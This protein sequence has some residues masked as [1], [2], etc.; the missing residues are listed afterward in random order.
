MKHYLLLFFVF[1]LSC[2]E[3]QNHT[4]TNN[5][6]YSY[7]ELSP[8][9]SWFQDNIGFQKLNSEK[10]GITFSNFISEEAIK[11]NRILTNGSGVASGDYNNDGLIDIYFSKLEGPNELYEN[12][13]DLKFK[14]VT[15][16]A[17]VSLSSQ[18]STGVVFEDINGDDFLDLIVGSLDSG[19]KLLINNGDGTF[20]IDS[21]SLKV[22]N[23]IYG[24]SSIAIADI[25]NDGDLD[26]YLTNYKKRSAKD[27]FPFERAFRHIV[28][29]EGDNYFIN[30]KFSEHYKLIERDSVILWYEYG[31][32][33]VLFLNNG[34]GT[35]SN[36]TTTDQSIF[37]TNSE[38]D[39]VLDWG[40]HARFFD[41][42]ND[43][44]PDLYVC[45]DFESP[46]RIW[47][48]QKDGT[49]KEIDEL[50]IRNTS[51][52]S[53]SVAFTDINADNKS[54]IFVA[55][56]LSRDLS[57]RNQQIG[58]M[59]PLPLP[60]GVVDNRPQYL[61]N[62][63]LVSQ[64]NG[65]FVNISDYSTLRASEWSWAS[66]FLDVDLDGNEDLVI[67]TGNYFDTQNADANQQLQLKLSSGRLPARDV[68][69]EYKPLKRPNKIFRNINGEYNFEDVSEEWGFLTEDISHGMS[70]ADLDNDGDLDVITNNLE[71]TAG[72]YENISSNNRIS[73]HLTG[74]KGNNEAVG[75]T[76]R[77]T[78]SYK[79]NTKVQNRNILAGG[80]YGSGS[81]K[82]ASFGI[83]DAE[84]VN[85]E[86]FWYNGSYSIFEDMDINKSYKFTIS[87]ESVSPKP[88]TESIKP[89]FVNE[90]EA[91]SHTHQEK[92]Y[93]DL[94]KKQPLLPYRLS[95]EGPW[96]DSIDFNSDS[97][98]DVLIGNGK[99][100]P[101]KL[102][103]NIE[104]TSFEEISLNHPSFKEGEITGIK[105]FSDN[106][107]PQAIIAVSYY[108]AESTK[109]GTILHLEFNNGEPVFNDLG[110]DD[111]TNPGSITIADYD[112]DGDSDFFVSGR[113]VPNKYPIAANSALYEN[114]NGEFALSEAHR[115]VFENLGLVTG[116]QFKDLDNDNYPELVISRELN[117]NKVYKNQKGNLTDISNDLP[118]SD[119]PGFWQNVT[120]GD[121]N[122]DGIQDLF[123]SNIGE[124]TLYQ[125]F[126]LTSDELRFYYPIAD[127]NSNLPMRIIE[128]YYDEN[129]QCWSPIRKYSVL[130]NA[131][132][133]L[134]LAFRSYSQF[135]KAC[136]ESDFGVEVEHLAVNYFK[137]MLL[138]STGNELEYK[139]MPLPSEL[140]FTQNNSAN[141]IDYNNDGLSDIFI[142]QNDFSFRLEIPRL[143]GGR[144]V[145]LKN[146]GGGNFELV[147]ASKSGISLYGDQK[148]TLV[149]D[150]NKDGLDDLIVTQ[151]SFETV[152]Y[153]NQNQN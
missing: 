28:G 23:K 124:N 51:L 146:A 123:F 86:I 29:Q 153:K 4:W 110:L 44:Y 150:Y 98:T 130:R 75:S 136:V 5:A 85:I 22:D 141:V 133:R 149:I 148:A 151:N 60:I 131:F 47:I 140:N 109:P 15:E 126:R 72:V 63:F 2:T 20:N 139:L 91:L 43:M 48:N 108:E 120:I 83:P 36:T 17:G 56:M 14:N 129:K 7:Q 9:S 137:N 122:N 80:S 64:D 73:V 59:I 97:F 34:N 61:G 81:Q 11:R 21:T 138:I 125:D 57:L 38:E 32:E 107:T 39:E 49:F 45:N 100:Y 6:D 55:E 88:E 92:F 3:R 82:I 119:K 118:I 105:S 13:G 132:P 71:S 106:S 19:T 117:S 142:S 102:Y 147:S 37:K 143:D 66:E 58:T 89:V 99:G 121:F 112:F 24:T 128:S 127:I 67:S 18:Y 145:L 10:T 90:K 33:D 30:E 116:A 152:L 111:V 95:Q 114:D 74:Y 40:L 78:S 1:I 70:T 96:A 103:K 53:M 135:S 113:S 77:V 68:M 50:S 46:D 52:S 94:I 16:Q 69:F 115:S 79:D 76:I 104:G 93:N 65:E 101:L 41:Y 25:E 62:T 42:N 27:I 134:S 84:K 144:G 31:E 54:D 87:D 35:F 26:I 12:L 8:K